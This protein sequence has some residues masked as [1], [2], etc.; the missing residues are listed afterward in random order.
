MQL[1]LL[2][3]RPGSP[4]KSV[5][6]S[7]REYNVLRASTA[8]ELS[9]E[10]ARMFLLFRRTGSFR[11]PASKNAAQLQRSA[12]VINR[13]YLKKREN[14]LG[15]HRKQIRL[16]LRSRSDQPHSTRKI[17]MVKIKSVTQAHATRRLTRSKAFASQEPDLSLLDLFLLHSNL[18]S[19]SPAMTP[20]RGIPLCTI[21]LLPCRNLW[22]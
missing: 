4:R 16:A 22:R 1:F 19:P 18:T 20:I 8:T 10:Q 5:S 13:E 17:F 21:F 11:K 7:M 3:R 15:Q 2:K 12:T 9:R 6:E 14:Q